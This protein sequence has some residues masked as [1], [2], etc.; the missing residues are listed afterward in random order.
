MIIK[1]MDA[2][3]DGVMSRHFLL[4]GHLNIIVILVSDGAAAGN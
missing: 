4:T 2:G 3:E 1:K